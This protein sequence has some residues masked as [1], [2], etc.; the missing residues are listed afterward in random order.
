MR[1]M[2][3]RKDLNRVEQICGS[4][5]GIVDSAIPYCCT[6]W[7]FCRALCPLLLRDPSAIL[8]PFYVII[9]RWRNTPQWRDAREIATLHFGITVK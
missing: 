6:H 2:S 3:A 9:V 5:R 7:P 1:N 4:H 8:K